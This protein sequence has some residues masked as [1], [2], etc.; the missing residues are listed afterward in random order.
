MSL[1][2]ASFVISGVI[3][4]IL[5]IIIAIASQ[6]FYVKPDKR[7]QI[8]YQMLPNINCG[9]CGTAGCEDMAG[10]LIRENI[11]ITKCRPAKVHE[12]QAIREKLQEMN[13]ELKG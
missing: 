9:Q 7:I 6:V 5:G 1:L 4:I 3:A 12:K 10:E 8:I 2:I 13:I 11:S